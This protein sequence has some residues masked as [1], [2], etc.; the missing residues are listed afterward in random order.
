MKHN[1][2]SY[3]NIISVISVLFVVIGSANGQDSVMQTDSALTI[4]SVPPKWP[5]LINPMIDMSN[6]KPAESTQSV[7]KLV[8]GYR[9]QLLAT[10][11][12][13]KADELKAKLIRKTAMPV[14]IS[15]E[16]PNYKVRVGNYQTRKEADVAQ[17]TLR[18]LGYRTAWVV[19]SRVLIRESVSHP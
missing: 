11:S 12:S 2:H 1:R 17:Q 13:E 7:E 19:Q 16:P 9:V 14:Y 5:M 3:L 15:F 8:S 10:R 4:K 6:N 18:A